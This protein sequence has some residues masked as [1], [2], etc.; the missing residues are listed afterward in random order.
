MVSKA[1]HHGVPKRPVSSD[2]FCFDR[3]DQV[4]FNAT[5]NHE[6]ASEIADLQMNLS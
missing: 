1:V 2:E 3:D 6:P 5:E 4:S